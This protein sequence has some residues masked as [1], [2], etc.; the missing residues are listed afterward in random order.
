[1]C[2]KGTALYREH[3][4]YLNVLSSH[5]SYSYTLMKYVKC[6]DGMTNI[7]NLDQATPSGGGL[8]RV[9]NFLLRPL[10]KYLGSIQYNIWVSHRIRKYMFFTVFSVTQM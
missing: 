9:S 8:T 6:S 3:P 1:M 2:S 5:Q 4:K 10:S 7:I